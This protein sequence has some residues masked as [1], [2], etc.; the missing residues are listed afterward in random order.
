MAIKGNRFSSAMIEYGVLELLFLDIPAAEVTCCSGA[1]Q[2]FDAAR[3]FIMTMTENQCVLAGCTLNHQPYG[4][5]DVHTEKCWFTK[6]A[7]EYQKRREAA[8][9]PEETA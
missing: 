4:V 3:A 1:Q 5:G 9:G 7:V 2:A 6:R 8:N